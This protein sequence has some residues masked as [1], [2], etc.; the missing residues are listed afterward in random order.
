M[1]RRLRDSST[2][3][4]I[5]ADARDKRAQPVLHCLGDRTVEALF[6]EMARTGGPEVWA[7]RRLRI[8]HGD[9]VTPDLIPQAKSM[10]V[11]VVR[12]PLSTRSFAT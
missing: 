6:K 4:P 3:R 8:E 2:S 1:T 11:I 5:L 10:G 12:N 9:G 7:A